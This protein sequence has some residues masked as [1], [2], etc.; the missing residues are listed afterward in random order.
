M[1][2]SNQFDNI[3]NS[4]ENLNEKEKDT[5]LYILEKDIIE[6]NSDLTIKRF[7]NSYFILLSSIWYVVLLIGGVLDVQPTWFRFVLFPLFGIPF[8][9]LYVFE[10]AN[11][12]RKVNIKDF[13]L[14]SFFIGPIIGLFWGLILSF[15]IYYGWKLIS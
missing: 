14:T 2:E 10:T 6:R 11:Y 9:I 13:L 5:L 4:L 7:K 15:I 3:V 8:A 12:K 1:S